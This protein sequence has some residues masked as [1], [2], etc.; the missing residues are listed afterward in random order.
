MLAATSAWYMYLLGTFQHVM[1]LIWR[2]NLPEL[3][4][5]STLSLRTTTTY[6]LCT[7]VLATRRDAAKTISY[8]QTITPHKD[9]AKSPILSSAAP[10]PYDDLV[11]FVHSVLR[12]CLMRHL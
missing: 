6:I 7:I 10:L 11:K 9:F 1:D 8:R 12:K 3:T 2:E 4:F 5:L